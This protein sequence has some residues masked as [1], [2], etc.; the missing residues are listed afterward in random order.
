MDAKRPP[1]ESTPVGLA[2][3]EACLVD[4]MAAIVVVDVIVVRAQMRKWETVVVV[5]I[6]IV[7]VGFAVEREKTV[8]VGVIPGIVD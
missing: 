6:R 2:R 5:V 8:V 7:V 1:D 4:S 3:Y